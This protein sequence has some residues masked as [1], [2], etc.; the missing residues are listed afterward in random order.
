MIP[1]AIL[2]ELGNS[3]IY[4]LILNHLHAFLKIDYTI[5]TNQSQMT[6][7]PKALHSKTLGT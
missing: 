6:S 7:F 3:L 1:D 2:C 4:P 5:E